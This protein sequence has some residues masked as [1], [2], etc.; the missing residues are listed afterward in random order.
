MESAREGKKAK[1]KRVA[2]VVI[3][4]AV[5]LIL[6]FLESFWPGAGIRRPALLLVYVGTVSFLLH[7]WFPLLLSVLSGLLLNALRG[8]SVYLLPLLFSLSALLAMY[9]K[10]RFQR[11][12][13]VWIGLLLFYAAMYAFYCMIGSLILSG[14]EAG[15]LSLL[16]EWWKDALVTVILGL[17]LWLPIYGSYLMIR[18]ESSIRLKAGREY[19]IS[20]RKPG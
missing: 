3:L 4:I 18:S 5:G 20:H 12:F 15:F 19:L 17:P 7:G 13:L 2:G 6:V 8:D 14:G 11:R 10:E 16:N 1:G 9:V